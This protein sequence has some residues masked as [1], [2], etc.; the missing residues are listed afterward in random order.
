MPDFDAEIE[1]LLDR[2]KEAKSQFYSANSRYE[3][4]IRKWQR[5]EAP[6]RSEYTQRRQLR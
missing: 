6:Y 2:A 3:R 4:N 1:K 5:S